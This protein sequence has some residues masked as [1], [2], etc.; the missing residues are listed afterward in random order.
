M[1]HYDLLGVAPAAAPEEIRAAY[2]T[3]AQIFHPDRLSHLKPESRAFAEE[4]LKALNAAYA[5]LSDPGRRAAYDAQLA[6][7]A[8]PAMPPRAGM[9]AGPLPAEGPVASRR[10]LLVERRRRLARL[11]AEIADLA[12][13]VANLE[14]EQRRAQL[15]SRNIGARTAVRFWLGTA[16]TSLGFGAVLLAAIGIFSQPAGA[17]SPTAARVTFVLLVALYEFWTALTLTIACRPPGGRVGLWNVV[18]ATLWGLVFAWAVGLA[19]WAAW[20]AAFGGALNSL[21]SLAGLALVFLLAHLAFC[22]A[23]LG[24]LPRLA[25]EQQRLYDHAYAPMLQAYQ[26]TLTQLRAQKAVIEA[27]TG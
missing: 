9:S 15:L 18:R 19:G 10:S 13:N 21:A 20:A 17:L 14:A 12:R 8:A 4:R 22:L 16:L 11:E 25:R 23:G 24:H 6:S 1:N 5:V 27:E 7:P 3:L 2:R 26:H